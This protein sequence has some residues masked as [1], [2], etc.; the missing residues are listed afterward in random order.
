MLRVNVFYISAPPCTTPTY[1]KE[2]GSSACGFFLSQGLTWSQ[3]NASCSA[4][5]A[6]LPVITTSQ[7]NQD[8]FNILVQ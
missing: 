8:F 7:E 5:E 4:M 1:F 2:D 3:A 6:R